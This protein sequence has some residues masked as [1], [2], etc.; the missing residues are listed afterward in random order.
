MARVD[1]EFLGECSARQ[2]TSERSERERYFELFK[3]NFQR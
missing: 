3:S 1:V 2:L